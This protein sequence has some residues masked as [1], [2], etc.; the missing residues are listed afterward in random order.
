MMENVPLS[1]QQTQSILQLIIP[2]EEYNVKCH[3]SVKSIP[4]QHPPGDPYTDI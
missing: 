1:T 3:G 4:M 2:S